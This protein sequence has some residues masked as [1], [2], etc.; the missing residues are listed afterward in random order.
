MKALDP[1]TLTIIQ[2][3]LK[4]ITNEMSLSLL[5]S[6]RS[7]IL[8]EANDFVT[9]VFD[10]GGRLLE[11]TEHV[12]VLAYALPPAM[13]Q[14]IRRFQNQIYPGDI[15]LHN[16]PFSG[17]NQCSDVKVVRPVFHQDRLVAW[18]AI[19]GH[20]AD[21][22]GGQPGGY[23]PSARTIFEE[24]IRI[25]PVKLFEA[26]RLRSDVW[27]LI[28]GNLRFDDLVE[29][30]IKAA[31]GGVTVGE[32]AFLELLGDYGH[33]A[34][35]RYTEELI[36]SAERMM[37]AEI[38]RIPDGVYRGRAV[39]YH[40]G[41]DAKAEMPVCVCVT[42]AGDKVTFDYA[43]SAPQSQGYVNSPLA[44]TLS[45]TML[46]L[47]MCI[48]VR[49]M[50]NNAGRLRP[51]RILVPEGS[52][53][54]PR[55]PAATGYGN[56]LADQISAA[57]FQALAPA[58]PERVTAGWNPTHNGLIVGRDPRRGK[59]FVDLLFMGSKG[60]SGAMR[61][62]DGYDHIGSIYTAGGIRAQDPEMFEQVNPMLIHCYEY[63][64]DSP[65][66]GRWRGGYGV[67]FEMEFLAPVDYISVIGDGTS[68]ASRPFGLFG[69]MAG[70]LNQI[71]MVYPD[72]TRRS[73]GGKEVIRDA[74]AGT[75]WLQLKA[76]GGGYGDPRERSRE[77]VRREWRQG[78]I[79]A[80]CAA[81]D[82][83]MDP[84][85]LADEGV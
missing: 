20:Q 25:P 8:S 54:H 23:N 30:D 27:E 34:L 81:R 70:C 35:V 41:F 53:L 61:E 62:H 4:A 78:L 67:R 47:L 48:D 84:E 18:M 14:V 49:T 33:E 65:G 60:G 85:S 16:D 63:A 31:I 82:Y 45:S 7:T 24:A 83:G 22:G 5:R 2:R 68:E 29:G 75:R 6:A 15:I 57:I 52:L 77:L 10:A 50:P 12:P 3:R 39:A 26:G 80:E 69:G 40:D 37:R 72:G 46:S 11:Q 38:A 19:S 43:G 17:G 32:R 13:E 64:I 55:F 21:V 42:V 73:V 56:H 9:A 79:S 76:G 66:A 51:I 71:E 58:L 36:D 1:A 59:P 44:A 28:F 74:P